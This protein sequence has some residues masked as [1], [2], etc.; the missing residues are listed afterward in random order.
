M[1]KKESTTLSAAIKQIWLLFCR[2]KGLLGSRRTICTFSGRGVET[3]QKSV[4]IYFCELVVKITFELTFLPCFFATVREKEG[5]GKSNMG[6]STA[7]LM[8]F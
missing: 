4:F 6:Q 2:Q 1:L 3:S 5:N 7:L 8:S